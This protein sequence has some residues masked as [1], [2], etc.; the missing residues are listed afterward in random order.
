MLTPLILAGAKLEEIL[1]PGPADDSALEKGVVLRRRLRGFPNQLYY[2][3]IPRSAGKR[4]PL[5]VSVHGVS[6][7]ARQHATVSC[8]WRHCS[9]KNSFRIT[10]GWA[11]SGVVLARTWRWTE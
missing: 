3:Y 5:M 7:N 8:C 11:A 10:S 6:R 9:V 1:S 4:P 2:L